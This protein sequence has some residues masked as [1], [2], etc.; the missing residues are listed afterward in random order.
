EHFEEALQLRLVVPGR[1][2]HVQQ[3]ANLDQGKA[4]PLAAHRELEA[5]A[6]AVAVNASPPRA[7]GREQSMV[8]VE[9]DGP[10]RQAEFPGEVGDGVCGF[11][12][13][14]AVYVN[15]K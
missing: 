8:L 5:H 10:C 6:V 14:A 13:G 12:H 11:L 3:L 4:E 9:P 15:V 7:L 2:V 1:V